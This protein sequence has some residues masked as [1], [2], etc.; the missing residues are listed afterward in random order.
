MLWL[1]LDRA[2]LFAT[3]P[4]QSDASSVTTRSRFVEYSSTILGPC[5]PGTI[6]ATSSR[7]PSFPPS[8]GSSGSTIATMPSSSPGSIA[9][10]SSPW[11]RSRAKPRN[12]SATRM[13]STLV[14]R[15]AVPALR[16]GARCDG[17]GIPDPQ[18]AMQ[19]ANQTWHLSSTYVA[20]HESEG[21]PPLFPHPG[22]GGFANRLAA[23]RS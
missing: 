19:E 6:S 12:G 10:A 23:A 9:L 14:G 1:G 3:S 20:V 8:P 2:I 5:G 17:R 18:A 22:F 15:H 11:F 4:C 13:R 16:Q 7:G 21:Q